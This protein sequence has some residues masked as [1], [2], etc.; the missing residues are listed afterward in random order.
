MNV[1]RNL[2]FLMIIVLLSVGLAACQGEEQSAA[3][4]VPTAAPGDVDNISVNTGVGVVSAEGEVVP[5][6]SAELSFQTGGTVAEILVEAGTAVGA[7]DPIMRLASSTLESAVQQAEAGVAAAEAN[8]AAAQAEL[9]VA[10]SGVARSQVGVT[11]AEAQLAQVRA[12]A[13]PQEIAAAEQGLAA[14]QA[15]VAQAAGNRDATLNVSSASVQA[16]EAELAAAI[17]EVEPLEDAYQQI[18]DACFEAPDG[19]E[20]CPLYGPVEENTRFQLEAARAN[21]EAAR[22]AVAEAQTGATEAERQAANAAVILAS[23]QVDRAQAE[24]DLLQAGAREEQIRQAEVGVEQAKLAVEQAEVAV[25]QAQAAISR[26]EANLTSAQAT[27]D[28]AQKALDRMTLNAP[29]AGT[30]SSVAVEVGE[31]VGPGVPVVRFADFSGWL[32]ETTDLT[33]LDIVAVRTGLPAEVTIDAIPGETLTGTVQEIAEVFEIV[34]G[35]VTYKVA[36]ELSDT[37]NLPLRWGMTAF[38][39]I[40]TE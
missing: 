28:S 9:E 23:A 7:G 14:A 10:R 39:N 17:A 21:V 32:V 20:V 25:M 3:T 35:D 27:L 19:S 40:D 2:L 30:V 29:F 4:A 33:E 38:V 5:L 36:I 11:S 31:L 1:R 34:R 22:Q 6:R 16:A 24:L 26:A 8:L 12:G 13:Q 18:L 37:Q 15:A